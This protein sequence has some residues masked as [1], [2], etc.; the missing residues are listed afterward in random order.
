MLPQK[1]E[2]EELGEAFL[3]INLPE[4]NSEQMKYLKEF[5]GN[6]AIDLNKDVMKKIFKDKIQVMDAMIL[7]HEFVNHYENEKE[8][9]DEFKEEVELLLISINDEVGIDI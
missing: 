8:L 1:P 2:I 4:Y 5:L 6:S 3:A 9:I 7:L